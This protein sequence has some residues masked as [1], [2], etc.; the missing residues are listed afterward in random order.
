MSELA[1]AISLPDTLESDLIR[2]RRE[3]HA[4]PEVLYD[5]V[6]PS[7]ATRYMWYDALLIIANWLQFHIYWCPCRCV[8]RYTGYCS[9]TGSRT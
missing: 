1:V 4:Y 9:G 8:A 3:L 7:V 2:I 6:G 5:V